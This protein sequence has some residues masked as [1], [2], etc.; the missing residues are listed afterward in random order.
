MRIIV[1]KL[2]RISPSRFTRLKGCS[3]KEVI[4]GSE[5]K[6]QLLPTSPSAKV[7]LAVHGFLERAGK[8][9]FDGLTKDQIRS[10]WDREIQS[11]E[12]E[13]K[14]NVLDA[15]LVPLYRN[16]RNF[17]V[18]MNLALNFAKTIADTRPA[19]TNEKPPYRFK[20]IGREVWLQ[21]SSGTVGGKVDCIE[22][23]E[24]GI[25][26]KDFKSGAII[27]GEDGSIKEQYIEQMKLYAALYFEE[28][29]V[30][31]KTLSLI[32]MGGET[33]NIPFTTDECVHL[34]RSAEDQLNKVNTAIDENQDALSS[35]GGILA[36]PS[37]LECRFCTW[38]PGCMTYW[39]NF[40]EKQPLPDGWP[41][42][43]SG[44]VRSIQK[45]NNGTCLLVL[46]E[47]AG[48]VVGTGGECRVLGINAQEPRFSILSHLKTS[49]SVRVTNLKKS[50]GSGG[51]HTTVFSAITRVD[52]E[53]NA[54]D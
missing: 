41:I 34:L 53:G 11:I 46:T 29:K 14:A 48:P 30:W 32:G 13:M 2:S 7:G 6:I 22:F 8:G 1:R 25:V 10:A 28:E 54:V 16:F 15:H 4:A 52:L 49:D 24:N 19:P 44:K 33:A 12:S 38:R 21:N 5:G 51:Y 37:I 27:D 23:N 36:T 20:K 42:D 47:S 3:L 31:P 17:E 45:L 39:E 35:L 40:S 9:E 43:V 50:G 18:K 26:L